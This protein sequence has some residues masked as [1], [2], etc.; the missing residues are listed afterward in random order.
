MNVCKGC[1]QKRGKNRTN[2][3]GEVKNWSAMQSFVIWNHLSGI[4]EDKDEVSAYLKSQILCFLTVEADERGDLILRRTTD[5]G[6]TFITIH[7]DIFSFG[8]IGA[9]LFFSV[10]EDS[11]R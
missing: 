1:T 4:D 3:N 6:K 8:Y 11:V 7:E 2:L 5:L 10:M 9:F